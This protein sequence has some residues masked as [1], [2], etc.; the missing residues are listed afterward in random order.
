[1]EEGGSRNDHTAHPHF[2]SADGRPDTESPGRGYWSDRR[3]NLRHQQVLNLSENWLIPRL[4]RQQ[5]PPMPL[6][7]TYIS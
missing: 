1:M 3:D 7:R 5:L 6:T 4:F 2:C